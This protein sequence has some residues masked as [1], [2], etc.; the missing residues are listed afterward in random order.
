ML[1][2]E[3]PQHVDS[4]LPR[5]GNA[6]DRVRHRLIGERVVRACALHGLITGRV[7]VTRERLTPCRERRAVGGVARAP[8]SRARGPLEGPLCP[9]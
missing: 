8:R 5:R 6:R 2:P 7:P 9:H 4:R 3:G 1:G